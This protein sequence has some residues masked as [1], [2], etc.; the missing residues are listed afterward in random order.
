M[1]RFSNLQEWTFLR[2]AN[3]LGKRDNEALLK[4]REKLRS[5]ELLIRALRMCKEKGLGRS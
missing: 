5:Q 2:I 1:C 3:D 4:S